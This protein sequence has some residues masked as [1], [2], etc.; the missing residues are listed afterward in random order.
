MKRMLKGIAV[1]LAAIFAVG[2]FPLSAMASHADNNMN[3]VAS[4]AHKNFIVDG[5]TAYYIQSNALYKVGLGGGSAEKLDCYSTFAGSPVY[6]IKGSLY[7]LNPEGLVKADKDGNVLNTY[8]VGDRHRGNTLRYYDGYF[9]YG[10]Y[11]SELSIFKQINRIGIDG[12]NNK[13]VYKGASGSRHTKL[14]G[15][16]KGGMYLETD[17]NILYVGFNGKVK[18]KLFANGSSKNYLQITPNRTDDVV[19]EG[20]WLYYISSMDGIVR[21]NMK[22]HKEEIVLPY[23]VDMRTESFKQGGDTIVYETGDTVRYGSVQIVD[24]WLYCT[25]DILRFREGRGF[26]DGVYD[27]VRVR[28]DGSSMSVLLDGTYVSHLVVDSKSSTMYFRE[29]RTLGGEKQNYSAGLNGS[30]K[31]KLPIPIW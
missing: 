21:H 29:G 9:Y 14:F 30:G 3:Y 24:G 11:G 23:K 16:D 25:R 18:T 12:K 15:F 7:F 27:I 4:T 19:R 2:M 8:S 10:V 17:G 22:T 5:N 31:K 1:L 26:L 6:L 20:D 28:P 13:V